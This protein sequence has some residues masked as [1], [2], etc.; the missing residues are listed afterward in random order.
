M[1]NLWID[2]RTAG[3]KSN[4]YLELGEHDAVTLTML[5]WKVLHDIILQNSQINFPEAAV[6]SWKYMY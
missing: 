6:M 3:Q 2:S 4:N 5:Y 1:I